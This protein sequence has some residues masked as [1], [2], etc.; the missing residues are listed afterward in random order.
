MEI[1]IFIIWVTFFSHI[2]LTSCCLGAQFCSTKEAEDLQKELKQLPPAPQSILCLCQSAFQTLKFLSTCKV[3]NVLLEPTQTTPLFL[4]WLLVCFFFTG[5]SDQTLSRT[6][7]WSS[8]AP[9][10]L[11]FS[12]GLFSSLYVRHLWCFKPDWMGEWDKICGPATGDTFV[13][14]CAFVC[15]T[16]KLQVR[17]AGVLGLGV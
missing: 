2:W 7:V 11:Y 17:L 8:P 10:Q 12:V 9:D 15:D 3:L 5:P 1:N 16:N 6:I 4:F 13:C 14:V